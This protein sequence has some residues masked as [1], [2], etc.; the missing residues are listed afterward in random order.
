MGVETIL[1][2]PSRT[3]ASAMTN[4][5]Q[6]SFSLPSVSRKKVT[7]AF[8]GGRLSS[9]SGV[10]LLAMA[11]RRRKVADTFAAHISDRRDRAHITHTVADV[12]R[13]RML[14][15]CCGYPD[16]NDF[17]RLR[18]DPAF[19]LACGRLPD[20]GRD[21]CS[22]PTISRWENAPTLREIIRL[23]YALVDIWCAS[24]PKPPRSIVLDIDDTVDV[25]HGHQQL[26]QWNAHY[27]ERCFLPIHV[28]DAATGA[29]VVV[30]LRPGKTPSG[31]EVRKLLSR[32]V[33]RI[34]RHWP[35]THIT[36]RGDGHYSRPEVMT[37][38][39][40]NGVDYIFGLPG[41][42]V[43][44]RL[45]EPVADDIR[46]RRAERQAEVLRGFTETRYAAKSWNKARRVVARI[47]ASTSHAD[48]MLRRGIDIRYVVTSLQHND[49]EHI[50]ETLYCARGQAENLIKQHKAQLA[51]D[52]TSCRSPLANQMRL[53]LHTG[54]YWLL[55]DLRTAIPSWNPLRHTEFATIRLRLLKIAGRIIETTSRIR[56]AL[57]ACCPEAETFSLIACRLQPSGP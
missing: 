5:N 34:R 14:A 23:T 39:E 33:G 54:A 7:A 27:D 21:L 22:Q 46:V 13:G 57:A 30:I 43:L 42:V 50:Y 51:S 17:E 32:L 18:G 20:S 1:R 24:Y 26:A 52:R 53:I 38:C 56:I 8:N 28:Y 40:N 2:I 37:W 47:E 15:I 16:G 35:E 44:D 45:V 3:A 9:D 41:N 25:V 49:A 31:V 6:L 10:L 48:D 12:L 11:E 19:K 55:L 29:P 36:L 4:N